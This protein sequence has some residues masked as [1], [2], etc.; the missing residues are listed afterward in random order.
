MIIPH[1]QLK[2]ETLQALIEEFVTR[3]GAVHGHDE[4]LPLDRKIEAVQRQLRLGKVVIVYDEEDESCSIMTAD[5]LHEKPPAPPRD[6]RVV[7][8]EWSQSHREAEDDVTE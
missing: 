3:Q 1:D 7:E 5:A 2:P 4:D 8:D 6:R